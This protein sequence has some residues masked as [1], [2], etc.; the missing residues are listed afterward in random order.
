L[1][2]K[3]CTEKFIFYFIWSCRLIIFSN[4]FALYEYIGH[5]LSSTYHYVN[6]WNWCCRTRD[7]VFGT[8]LNFKPNTNPLNK[9]QYLDPNDPA[10]DV[11]NFP[12]STASVWRNRFIFCGSVPDY[13]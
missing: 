6:D 10:H 9:I 13:G 12:G 1:L 5:S 4:N 11:S 2:D 3:L 7:H 8:K